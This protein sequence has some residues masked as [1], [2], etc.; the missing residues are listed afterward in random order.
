MLLLPFPLYDLFV[1]RGS[2]LTPQVLLESTI[3]IPAVAIFSIFLFGVQ[4]LSITLEEPFSVL[5][6]ESFCSDIKRTTTGM[7][8]RVISMTKE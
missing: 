1:E 2:I 4:E 7:Q 3:L 5:N 8:N 6:M